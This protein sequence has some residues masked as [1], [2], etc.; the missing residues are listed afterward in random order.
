M[1]VYL[2]DF[3]LGLF[4]GLFAY[5]A[6]APTAVARTLYTV[7]WCVGAVFVAFAYLGKGTGPAPFIKANQLNT[8]YLII[9][10]LIGIACGIVGGFKWA[11][12]QNHSEAS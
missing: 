10:V 7:S 11:Q 2:T 8:E 1:F 9:T 3:I 4:V 5:A 6:F 12:T